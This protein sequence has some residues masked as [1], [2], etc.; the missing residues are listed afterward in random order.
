MLR[1][2]RKYRFWIALL[3]VA[4]LFLGGSLSAQDTSVQESKKAVLEKEISQLK[5]LIDDNNKLTG[6]ALAGLDLLRS[7]IAARKKLVAES[8]REIAALKDSVKRVEARA[9]ALE[10]RLDTLSSHY[11]RLVRSAYKNRDARIWYIYVL[12]SR[13]FAQASRRYAYFRSL[14][15]QMSSS[16]AKIKE[17]QSSLKDEKAHLSEM[18]SAADKLRE[19]RRSEVER[20]SSEQAR[21]DKMVSQLK[22]NKTKYQK[23]LSTKKK[24][25]EALNKQIEKIIAQY[26]A[27]NSK[28]SSGSGS[29]KSSA[30]VDYKL[31]S[32]F[33]SNKGR[34]PWPADGPVV[35]KFGRHSH[36]V[37]KSIEMPFSNGIS[38]GLP[39][40]S[41][42]KAVFNGEVRRVIV[43][44][45]YNKCVLVQHGNYFTFYC[46]L[47]EVKVKAGDK[48]TTGQTLG[49]VDTIDGQTQ[50]HLQVWKEKTPQNPESWLR[51]K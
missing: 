21:S 30:A 14:S 8:D 1:E 38:I 40:N 3:V 16:A 46:K 24:Q 5:K 10:E 15:S 29:S 19:E 37:Y 12:S 33:E 35:E 41:E 27:E 31:A 2:G 13:D 48:V 11:S 4:A 28:K 39:A 43:M 42:V 49:L 23:Q 17:T 44:P 7:Q 36:P 25:V 32:E 47:G 22:R 34:L 45:G 20:L 6:N 50:L 9:N 26:V 51:P 18:L